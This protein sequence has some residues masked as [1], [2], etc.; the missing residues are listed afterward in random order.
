MRVCVSLLM[1]F[2]GGRLCVIDARCCNCLPTHAALDCYFFAGCA[3]GYLTFV[4]VEMLVARFGDS[5]PDFC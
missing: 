1:D 3:G 2:Y 5:V 4:S